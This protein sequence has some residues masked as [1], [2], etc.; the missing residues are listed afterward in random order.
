MADAIVKGI[1]GFDRE[2]AFEA[3]TKTAMNPDRGNGLR[4]K[5]G[6]IPCDL[7]NAAVAYDMEYA[8]ADGAAARA[9]EALGRTEEANYFTERSHSYRNCFDPA[10]RFMR[11]RDSKGG[12]RTPFNPSPRRTVPTTTARATPGSTRGS[13]RTTS[14]GSSGVSAAARRCSESSIRSSR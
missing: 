10:T 2:K 8:L 6:Y 11:G 12:W 4:M 1:E 9:A 7:F 13:C 5:Y 14:R 3:I